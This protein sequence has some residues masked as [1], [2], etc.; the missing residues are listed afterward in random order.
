M[1]QVSLVVVCNSPHVERA[2]ASVLEQTRPP[3]EVLVVESGAHRLPSGARHA[4]ARS[5]VHVVRVELA[6]S[7]AL[8]NAGVRA[9][10]GAWVGLL[11]ADDR[12]APTFLDEAMR[13]VDTGVRFITSRTR[14]SGDVHVGSGEP[15]DL[16][17]ALRSPMLVHPSSLFRRDAWNELGGFDEALAGDEMYDFWL[18]LLQHGA[19]GG[20]IDQPLY[21]RGAGRVSGA[22]SRSESSSP[23]EASLHQKHQRAFA[24]DLVGTI[25][26]RDA[27]ADQLRRGYASMYGQREAC[28]QGLRQIDAELG[29]ITAALRS[30][31][32]DRIE[33]GDLNRLEPFSPAAATPSEESI[34]TYY[35]RLFLRAHAADLHGAVLEVRADADLE[36]GHGTSLLPD[37][38]RAGTERRVTAADLPAAESAGYDCVILRFAPPGRRGVQAILAECVRILKPGSVLLAAFP[39]VG[40]VARDESG[41]PASWLGTGAAARRLL[42]ERFETDRIQVRTYGNVLANVATLYGLPARAITNVELETEDPYFPV[43]IAARVQV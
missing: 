29:A 12:L 14:L 32:R 13:L 30:R 24:G 37:A 7:A 25:C 31:G 10:S 36:R 2:V 33:W 11:D 39:L 1:T 8:R 6:G 35:V 4:L 34:E 27:L 26:G 16:G 23:A 17:A 28:Q 43:L 21:E 9:T 19:A 5:G 38:R 3:H 18:R 42:E 22:S 41:A 20:I 15:L 40:S